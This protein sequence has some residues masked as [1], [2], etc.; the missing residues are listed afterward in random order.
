MREETPPVYR[1]QSPKVVIPC[2]APKTQRLPHSSKRT[3]LVYDARMRF[4][5][6]PRDQEEAQS[7]VHPEDPRRIL[8]IYKWLWDAGLVPDDEHPKADDVYLLWRLDIEHATAAQICLVHTFAHYKQIEGYQLLNNE[9]LLAVVEES[10]HDSIYLHQETF[11]SATLSAGG[12]IAA[13]RAVVAGHVKNVI[14]V[15]RPPGHHAEHDRPM[16][17]CF[18]NNVSIAARV[19]QNDFPD[20]CR[21]ILIVDWDVH[22]GNG[23]QKAFYDDP[24]VL[25][26]SLHVYMN[27]KFYP[28]KKEADHRHCGEGAGVGRNVNIP[29]S[30]Q[31]M[32]DSDYIYA[33][34]QVVMPIAQEFNPDLVIVSAGFDAAEGDRLGGCHVTPPCYAHMTHMLM[35]LANGKLVVCLEGG[36]NLTSIAASSVAVTRTLMGEPPERLTPQDVPLPEPTAAGRAVVDMVKRHQSRYWKCMYPKYVEQPANLK[37]ELQREHDEKRRSQSKELWDKYRMTELCI[38]NKRVSPSFEQQVLA[39]PTFDQDRPLLLIFHDPPEVYTFPD[40]NTNVVDLHNIITADVTKHYIDWAVNNDFGVIDINIPKHVTDSEGPQGYVESDD[41]AER[42]SAVKDLAKY[43]WENY[44]ELRDHNSQI[45]FMGQNDSYRGILEFLGEN[46]SATDSEMGV[47]GVIG[48]VG[49]CV[50]TPIRRPT[51]DYIGEWYYKRSRVFVSDGHMA[52]KPERSRKIRKKYGQLIRSSE[53]TMTNMLAEHLR[54]VQEY[55]MTETM[56]WRE[57]RKEES[58]DSDEKLPS[59]KMEAWAHNGSASPPTKSPFPPV[60]MF[61][62]TGPRSSA[63]PGK[64]TRYA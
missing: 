50:L 54:D 15:I 28:S 6:E 19:C 23:V 38:V 55:L 44:I 12:A 1:A 17:F 7:E 41:P 5:A 34:Q 37:I 48:F 47:N 3:G 39:T 8:E 14:A 16:G 21:K 62:V 58:D 30:E 9:Q 18:F 10:Q 45:F 51:D 13:C 42:V 61:G 63:S 25:Y 26:I 22:H 20:K 40:P 53:S 29:W 35:S 33:F 36:Y 46:E 59:I 49:E 11:V 56:E 31:G 43:L 24:N 27:G 32:G 57:N 52:W 60:G 4:H 2:L 64:G